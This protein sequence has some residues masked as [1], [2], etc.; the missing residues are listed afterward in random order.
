MKCHICGGSLGL[1]WYTRTIT[2][3]GEKIDVPVCSKKCLTKKLKVFGNGLALQV[4]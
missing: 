2:V 1:K 4:H 3:G